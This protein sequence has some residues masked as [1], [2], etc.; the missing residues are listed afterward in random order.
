MLQTANINHHTISNHTEEL[1]TLKK[2]KKMHGY[3]VDTKGLND[4]STSVIRK[5]FPTIT[6]F[7]STELAITLHKH[8]KNL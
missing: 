1:D 3:V 4:K 6:F 5:V 8:K 2:K 7:F